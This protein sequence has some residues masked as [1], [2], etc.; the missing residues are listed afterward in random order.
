MKTL[1]DYAR[2]AAENLITDISGI[3]VA[4]D[5]FVMSDEADEGIT[6]RAKTAFLAATS[7][8]AAELAKK[9]EEIAKVRKNAFDKGVE[10]GCSRQ[11]ILEVRGREKFIQEKKAELTKESQAIRAE[12]ATVR[13]QLE[14][15][16]KRVSKYLDYNDKWCGNL[17][18]SSAHNFLDSILPDAAQPQ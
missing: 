17:P 13:A 15:A 11:S 18:A 5:G 9:D 8:H 3:L 6:D 10:E 14:E 16:Q 2:E 1:E 12:L 4:C 7:T